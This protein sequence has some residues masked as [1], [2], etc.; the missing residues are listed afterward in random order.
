[1]RRPNRNPQDRKVRQ[2]LCA[3]VRGFYYRHEFARRNPAVLDESRKVLDALGMKHSRAR[4]FFSDRDRGSMLPIEIIERFKSISGGERD[5][6]AK[7]LR[8]FLDTYR[9]LPVYAEEFT[10][11][12]PQPGE[13]DG[14]LPCWW[15]DEKKVLKKLK[16]VVALMSFEFFA[17]A[18]VKTQKPILLPLV[19]WGEVTH[20]DEAV[21]LYELTNLKN[22]PFPILTTLEMPAYLLDAYFR[23]MGHLERVTLHRKRKGVDLDRWHRIPWEDL[24]WLLQTIDFADWST[25]QVGD[26]PANRYVAF[27]RKQWRQGRGPKRRLPE[28]GQTRM[29]TDASIARMYSARLRRARFW[30][31]NYRRLV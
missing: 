15:A 5:R 22:T 26:L 1:M 13:L 19:H 2:A 24:P 20:G 21:S 7:D 9:I 16:I 14:F 30:S 25:K 11:Q 23:I 18:R 3:V 6:V 17:M 28:R 4:Y 12:S 8:D 27:C 29:P 31:E 10:R